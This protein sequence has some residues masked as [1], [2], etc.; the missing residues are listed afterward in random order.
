MV[1]VPFPSISEAE[2]ATRS[3]PIRLDEVRLDP[4]AARNILGPNTELRVADFQ[5]HPAYIGSRSGK[6][7]VAISAIDGGKLDS[8]GP[9]QAA[10]IAGQYGHNSTTRVYGP[11]DYDQWVVPQG[12]NPRRPL[13]RVSLADHAH[14]QIYLS[15]RT[16]EVVQATTRFERGWNWVGSVVHWIYFVPI[17]KSFEIWNWTVWWISL[18]GMAIV[19]AGVWLGIFRTSKKMKSKRPAVT[20][21]RGLMSWHHV[22]G[23]AAGAFVLFWIFSGWLSMD[24]GLLFSE[25]EAGD[26]QLAAYQAGAAPAGARAVG[27]VLTAADLRRFG[28]VSSIELSQLAGHDVALGLGPKGPAVLVSTPSGATL[29]LRVPTDLIHEALMA[30]WPDGGFTLAGKVAPDSPYAKAESLPDETLLYRTP[31]MRL[32]IDGVSGKVLVAMDHS[33]QAYAWLYYMLHTYNFPGLSNRPVLRIVLILIPLTLGF[34]FSLTSLL[35]GVRRLW[36]DLGAAR[37]GKTPSKAT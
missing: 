36:S 24:H 11:F 35:V 9:S 33:R 19:I 8:V 18:G 31:S 30:G 3:E 28:A 1:F 32:Y 7:D 10:A 15:S 12:L 27:P 37:I 13:Y 29:A 26:A 23:L 17:R 6:P 2:R 25:G 14:T 16:A 4:A 20:P 22:V 34:V 5:G 21:Y